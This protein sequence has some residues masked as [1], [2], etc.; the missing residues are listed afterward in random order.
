MRVVLGRIHRVHRAGRA[1]GAAQ[2]GR[3]GQP[4]ELPRPG[5]VS[6]DDADVE[7]QVVLHAVGDR[8]GME[9][10]ARNRGDVEVDDGADEPA[11]GSPREKPVA[12]RDVENHEI[13]VDLDAG[14]ARLASHQ[15]E[16]AHAE[17][18]DV[19]SEGEAGEEMEPRG[20][21]EKRDDEERREELVGE[22][23]ELPE[24][25]MDPG[26]R[27]ESEEGEKREGP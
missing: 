27:G 11:D 3:V 15:G 4:S 18:R 17:I 13:V 23:E 25:S 26:E 12:K 14:D 19:Q 24:A 6:A 1:V 2:R 16:A 7:E 8:H 21:E 9:L 10:H 5:V 22:I 20:V